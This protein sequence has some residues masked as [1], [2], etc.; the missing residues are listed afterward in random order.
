MKKTYSY[1]VHDV[2]T[3][4]SDGKLPELEP[5]QVETSIQEPTI[6]VRVGL[7]RK[8]K[9]ADASDKYMYYREMFG[10]LGFEVS[11]DLGKDPIDV[12]ASP[13]LV[14]A[15]ICSGPVT[16]SPRVQRETRLGRFHSLIVPSTG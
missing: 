9:P 10:H 14:P 15:S 6:R 5:F 8:Q 12:V 1:N 2:V 7:P 4:V 11:L 13:M 16:R 3:V